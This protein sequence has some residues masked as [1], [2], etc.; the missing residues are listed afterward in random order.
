MKKKMSFSLSR[1]IDTLLKVKCVNVA[2]LN[3]LA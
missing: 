2:V 3:K 1:E